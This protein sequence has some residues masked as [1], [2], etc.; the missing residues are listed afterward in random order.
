MTTANILAWIAIGALVGIVFALV[1]Q[2]KSSGVTLLDVLVGGLG[3]FV[4]GVLLN[5]VGGI[6]GAEIIGVNLSGLVVALLG[7][8]ILVAL[9][10]A[11]IR[12]PT[13]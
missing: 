3:G 8:A 12:T 11:V 4:G 7:A 5:A 2:N 6:V 10:E 1:R 13:D 9:L